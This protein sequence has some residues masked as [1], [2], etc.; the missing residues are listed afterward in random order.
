MVQ[1]DAGARRADGHADACRTAC[2]W[3]ARATAHEH[4]CAVVPRA[5]Q[6]RRVSH[7]TGPHGAFGHSFMTRVQCPVIVLT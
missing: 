5:L 1:V 4:G 6:W 7:E 2:I 3:G